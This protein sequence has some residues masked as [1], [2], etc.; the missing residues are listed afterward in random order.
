MGVAATPFYHRQGAV[1]VLSG[2]NLTPG[3]SRTVVV[4]PRGAVVNGAQSNVA[5]IT[6][7]PGHNIVSGQKFMVGTDEAK[8]YTAGLSVTTTSIPLASGT[9][10]VSDGDVLLNLGN[11][12][13]TTSPN[14][15]TTTTP[16]YANFAN[17]SALTPS[18]RTTS[19]AGKYEYWSTEMFVWELVLDGNGDPDTII[20][21]IALARLEDVLKFVT[22][23]A[24]PTG[25]PV[26]SSE[27]QIYLKGT[28]LVVRFNDGGTIRYRYMEL[29]GA[30]N[31]SI[32]TNSTSE[33]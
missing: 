11:D 5:A 12:S 21:D 15:D 1:D 17:S 7:R 18:T 26:S 10:T 9:A 30:T 14:Y 6:V 27:A 20:R 19:S 31:P 3:A 32:W 23:A 4:L 2:S 22:I 29:S 16:I 24:G 8:F 33:P 13:G 28:K 25:T